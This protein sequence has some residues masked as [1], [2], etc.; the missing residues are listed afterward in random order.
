MKK[1]LLT[2]MFLI[3]VLSL[4]AQNAHFT[5]SGTIEYNKTSNTYAMIERQISPENEG[6][7]RPF[8]DAY[9]KANPQFRTLKSIL[10][11]SGDKTLFTPIEPDNGGSNFITLPLA[12]QNNTIYNDLGTRITTNQKTVFDATFLIKDTTRKIKWKITGETREVAGYPCRRANG[13]MMDS[14]YVVAF[15]TE[16]IH[17]SGGPE[18]FNGLPGMILEVAVPHEN[19][20]WV[21]TKVTDV[22]VADNAIHPPKKGKPVTNAQ[23]IATLHN[24]TKDWGDRAQFYLKGFVF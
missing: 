18:S 19:I 5:T 4:F 13:I 22:P 8:F 1:A 17:T 20:I 11:F 2:F 12:D 23:L 9:K 15:Y 21:A 24:L 16:K 7:Y 3:L 6:F 14:I 10:T